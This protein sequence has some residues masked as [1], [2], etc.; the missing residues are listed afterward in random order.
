MSATK[1]QPRT[2]LTADGELQAIDADPEAVLAAQSEA[3]Y[4]CI[5][6]GTANPASGSYCRTCGHSLDEQMIDADPLGDHSAPK[7]LKRAE[8]QK[9]KRDAPLMQTT[10]EGNPTVQSTEFSI[11]EILS[12]LL[13]RPW[14]GLLTLSAIGALG[15][16]QAG[17]AL[18]VFGGLFYLEISRRGRLNAK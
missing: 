8:R 5:H 12:S 7:K 9:Q 15:S 11:S 10:S 3:V 18:I 13:R 16:G 4:C 1:P 14:I 2:I 6:C 17:V